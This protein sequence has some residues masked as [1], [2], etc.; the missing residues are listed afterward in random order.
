VDKSLLKTN[1]VKL[2]QVEVDNLRK[3]LELLLRDSEGVREKVKVNHMERAK[4][5]EVQ[6]AQKSTSP[7]TQGSRRTR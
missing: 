3:R 6:L 5:L 7:P 1:D 2:L 4:E